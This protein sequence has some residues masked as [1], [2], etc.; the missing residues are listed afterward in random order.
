[1]RVLQKLVRNG[2]STQLT[3]PKTMLIQLGWIPSDIVVIE[4]LEDK[5]ILLTKWDPPKRTTVPRKGV[6]MPDAATVQS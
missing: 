2:H 4:V 3:L 5:T 1:M 6:Q